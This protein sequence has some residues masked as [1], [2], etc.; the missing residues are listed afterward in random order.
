MRAYSELFPE[1]WED[2]VSGLERAHAMSR[3]IENLYSVEQVDMFKTP[4]QGAAG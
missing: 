4:S 2:L 1:A 3:E